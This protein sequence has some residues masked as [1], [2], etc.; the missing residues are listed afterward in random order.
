MKKKIFAGLLSLCL[1]ATMMPSMAY[2]AT[3]WDAVKSQKLSTAI[4][5]AT[6]NSTKLQTNENAFTGFA[7]LMNK[8]TAATAGISQGEINSLFSQSQGKEKLTYDEAVSDVE[9]YFKALKY[10]YGAYE[11][12]GGD[13]R[14]D[15]AKSQVLK[16]LSGK[17]TVS[18]NNLSTYLKNAMEFVVDG[19]FS[20]DGESGVKKY[21]KDYQYY[22][23]T[24]QKFSKDSKGYYKKLNGKKWYYKSCSTK[25]VTMQKSLTTA[26]DIVYSPV[27]FCAKSDAV[28]KSTITL[29]NGKSKK[30]ETVKWT[31]SKAFNSSSSCREPDFNYLEKN[32]IAYISIRNFDNNYENE[33]SKFVATGTQAQNAE[34]IIFDIRSNG[35]GSDEYATKWIKNF[36]GEDLVLN[37]AFSRKESALTGG[38][39]GK[40]TYDININTG[41]MINNNIPIVVLVDDMCG[42]AGESMLCDLRAL[43]NVIVIGSNSAGYQLCGNQAE[44]Q[45]PN[46]GIWIQ[47]GSSLQFAYEMK[48]VDGKGYT[49]DI[50]CD[51]S[52]ALKSVTNMLKKQKYITSETASY[53]NSK[54]GDAYGTV[55]I[56]FARFQIQPGGSF[57]RIVDDK[58]DVMCAGKKITNY[59]AKSSDS[60]K[61]IVERLSNGKLHLKAVK[62][63]VVDGEH[64][65]FTITYS[66]KTYEFIASC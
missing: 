9:L 51:P 23:N 6:K 7:D 26:G 21:T 27:L 43:D 57:G 13:T 18:R 11:Y 47:F 20:I 48:N 41:Y 56:S 28:K 4:T 33:L 1:L 45:L 8:N 25:N 54:I 2:G 59:T 14:F 40:E 37:L 30:K 38:T 24:T 49:P 17:S 22:Y 36:T 31:A 66:G 15:K 63:K 62:G 3:K 53:F 52:K 29:A 12:F 10:G 55:M 5:A 50:W 44:Y 64:V 35:G 58:L 65:N 42:S 46:S 32:N 60:S 16:K 61:L 39:Y 34:M 19:H